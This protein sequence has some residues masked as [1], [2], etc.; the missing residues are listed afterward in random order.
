MYANMKR[1]QV[2]QFGKVAALK[3]VRFLAAFSTTL[4]LSVRILLRTGDEILIA[5][6]RAARCSFERAVRMI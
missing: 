3:T 6:L 5:S 4:E 1:S 2:S